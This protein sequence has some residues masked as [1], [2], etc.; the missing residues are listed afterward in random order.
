MNRSLMLAILLTVVATLWVLSGSLTGSTREP[1]E[2]AV[3]NSESTGAA[4]ADLFKVKA[5]RRSVQTMQD[6]IELQGAIEAEREIHIR[7]E[8][9][10]T[11][12]RIY[13]QQGQ[14][15]KAGEAILSLAI[16]DRQAR[17]EQ[18]RAQLKL[19]KAELSS[20]QSLKQKNMISENQHQ[21][22]LADV[23]AA[24][25]EIKMIEVEIKQTQ[26]QAAFAGLLNTVQVEEGDYVSPGTALA[27]L[28]DQSHVIITTEV[29]QQHIAKLRLG[30]DVEATLLDGRTVS[31]KLSYISGAANSTTRTFQIEARADNDQGIEHF[32]QS[33]QVKIYL[34][35]REAYYLPASLL[36]LD[37]DG[38]LQIKT[39]D[40]E[41]RVISHQVEIIRSDNA[42]LWL[43]GLPDSIHLITVG[44]GFVAD[45][46]Q[47]AIVD[48]NMPADAAEAVQ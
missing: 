27:T 10:G 41:Q 26:I 25:A 17:L 43:S 32:G 5:E 44:Q 19:K 7:A 48:E 36:N 34:G 24:E 20:S 35:Q 8:T 4:D 28:V 2:T 15:L 47:V 14:H 45:G 37:R 16:N 29:P 42:G 18:A 39:L 12:E 11:I 30:Q 33:A 1:P 23:A 22:R 40:A 46:E 38:N 31:G 3:E 13:A 9:E 21:Q 6:L